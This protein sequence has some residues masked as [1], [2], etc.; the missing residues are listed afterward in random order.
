MIR[1]RRD[2]CHLRSR[3][4]AAQRRSCRH[5]PE[6]LLIVKDGSEGDE[7]RLL[8]ASGG[9]GQCRVHHTRVRVDDDLLARRPREQD[10]RHAEIHPEQERGGPEL[11]LEHLKRAATEDA[12]GGRAEHCQHRCNHAEHR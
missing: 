12:L 1:G 5:P 7:L 3:S 9:D 10:W 2:G 6:E 11:A 4:N 8:M